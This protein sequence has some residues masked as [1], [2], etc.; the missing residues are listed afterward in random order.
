MLPPVDLS[1]QE[2]SSFSQRDQ[3]FL[4]KLKTKWY[5]TDMQYN[6]LN[7]AR[8][9]N[10]LPAIQSP[11]SQPGAIKGMLWQA[12]EIAG[13][14][15]SGIKTAGSDIMDLTDGQINKP[16]EQQGF[17]GKSFSD[18]SKRATNYSNIM[19]EK[20]PP[21]VASLL[22]VLPTRQQLRGAGQ[23][24][25]SANDIF[26]NIFTGILKTAVPKSLREQ[27]KDVAKLAGGTEFGQD[28]KSV[29]QSAFDK[30]SQFKETNPELA[31]DVEASGNIVNFALNF[32]WGGAVTKSWAKW[33]AFMKSV[34]SNLDDIVKK[35][36]PIAKQWLEKTAGV[37]G[38][39]STWAT[40]VWIST[41]TGLSREAQAAIK[42]TPELYQSARR[43]AITREWIT[44]DVLWALNKRKA[45]L[46]DLGKGYESVRKSPATIKKTDI[47]EVVTNFMKEKEI[48]FIDLPVKDRKV[49]QQAID[50]VKEYWDVL[51]SKNALSLRSKL[52]DLAS[53]GTE[54]TTEW[55]RFIRG[56][57]AKID[58]VLWE[59]IPWLKD[60]D[61]KYGPE[62]EFINKVKGLVQNADG[63]IKDNAISTIANLVGKNKEMKLARIEKLIPG[64]WD[65]VR[66]LKAFE[67]I[68]NLSQI[69]TGAVA[70]QIFSFAVW[71][72]PG[73]VAT[74]PYV[75]GYALEKYWFAKKYI[76]N[77]LS[78]GKNI[79]KE[80]ISIVKKSLG[81]V[82]KKEVENILTWTKGRYLLKEWGETAG[83]A[84]TPGK[85][86]PVDLTPPSSSWSSWAVVKWE[87]G[88]SPSASV[89]NWPVSKIS[90]QGTQAVSKPKSPLKKL[91][92][93]DD[94]IRS[95]QK[96]QVSAGKT[97]YKNLSDAEWYARLAQRNIDRINEQLKKNPSQSVA[98]KL[99]LDL[100]YEKWVL[101][102]AVEEIQ[103]FK[104]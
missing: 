6:L 51:S 30:W 1:V 94:I 70:R 34:K 10:G 75:V 8:A 50:Y 87:S 62:R 35:G 7:Q 77:L 19:S 18:V 61:R 46:S 52:D 83:Y 80:E 27:T 101:K 85:L 29:A 56:L 25:W 41:A 28:V 47:G 17:I 57:R 68:Q 97:V 74:N 2:S 89:S 98:R 33:D 4:D 44:E 14:T 90:T 15:W 86:P 95:T 103:K 102:K 81:K 37:A 54:A 12:K 66:A 11:S 23:L 63:T 73:F 55:K 3:S 58:G 100:K 53:W 65:K 84:S 43:G 104:N 72:I 31:K 26:W 96:K 36:T 99:R 76:K 40:E 39:M 88:V 9:K 13:Q 45:D 16:R 92:T 82:D 60:L 49:I 67:E 24:L 93:N 21:T 59:K 69:K 79:S 32:V 38:K 91:K 48:S 64:F 22:W 42:T 20:Q 5:S 71:G 78:K